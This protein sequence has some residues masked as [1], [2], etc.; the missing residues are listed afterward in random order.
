MSHISRIKTKIV[1]KEYLLAALK[2]LGY[3]IEEISTVSGFGAA[4]TKVDLKVR[5]RLSSDIGFVKH[6]DSYD[7]VADWFSVHGESAKNFTNKVMQQYAYQATRAKLEEQGFT[8]VQQTNEKGKIQMVLRR[9][10]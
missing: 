8:L 2:E 9:M 1:E 6:G 3:Q 4:S 10:G 5:L 7:I